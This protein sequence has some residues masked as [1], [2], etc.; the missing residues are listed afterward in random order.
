ML[1]VDLES[2]E[3]FSAEAFWLRGEVGFDFVFDLNVHSKIEVD[4]V[5]RDV[6][7]NEFERAVFLHRWLEILFQERLSDSK[8]AKIQ[9]LKEPVV[10]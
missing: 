2:V 7:Y 9:S 5:G 3:S 1:W 10:G 6:A 4:Y 8:A